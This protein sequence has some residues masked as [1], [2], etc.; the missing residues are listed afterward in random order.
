MNKKGD[1]VWNT[2]VNDDDAGIQ[3]L[4][5]VLTVVG[6]RVYLML[7]YCKQHFGQNRKY[8][9]TFRVSAIHFA[10]HFQLC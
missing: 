10:T 4:C 5:D 7:D 3:E 8:N 1:I 6:D 2:L 9:S